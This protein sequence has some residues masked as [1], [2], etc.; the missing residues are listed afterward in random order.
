[1]NIIFSGE[2]VCKYVRMHVCVKK[3]NNKVKCST[4]HIELVMGGELSL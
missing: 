4:K 3:P 2:Y 1:M